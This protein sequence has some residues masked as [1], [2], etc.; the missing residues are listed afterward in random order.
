ML[1]VLLLIIN[2]GIPYACFQKYSDIYL[3]ILDKGKFK[4][5]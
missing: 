1:L 2:P 4:L 5:F 3:I